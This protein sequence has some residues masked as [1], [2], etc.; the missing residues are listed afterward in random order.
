MAIEVVFS[1]GPFA[2]FCLHACISSLRFI[3]C[4]SLENSCTF[5]LTPFEISLPFSLFIVA[6]LP[7]YFDS[8][9]S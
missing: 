1:I 9:V 7:G 8:A 5:S 3:K 4:Y 6:I 2:R